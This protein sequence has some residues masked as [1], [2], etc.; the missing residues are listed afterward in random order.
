VSP[1]KPSENLSV[2][3]PL[4]SNHGKVSYSEEQTAIKMLD[5]ILVFCKM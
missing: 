4:S 5:G 1:L 3:E 2:L